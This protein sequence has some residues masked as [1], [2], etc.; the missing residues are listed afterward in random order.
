MN[1]ETNICSNYCLNRSSSLPSPGCKTQGA[2]GT[3][4]YLP[5]IKAPADR[6]QSN[7]GMANSEADC[8]CP[9]CLNCY[10][11][12]NNSEKEKLTLL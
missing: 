3:C 5:G 8:E 12:K 4:L 6:T 1:F 7:R 2:R 11:I 10:I 9:L